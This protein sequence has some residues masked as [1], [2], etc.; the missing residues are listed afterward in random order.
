MRKKVSILVVLAFVSTL[1]LSGFS[2][3]AAEEESNYQYS[4]QDG[5]ATI[6]KYIGTEAVITVPQTLDGYSVI[7]IGDRAF[8]SCT[9]LTD[10]T[11]LSGVST[12]ERYAFVACSHLLNIT[13]P[14]TITNIGDLAFSGT[15][16]NKA[17]IIN[18]GTTLCYVPKTLRSYYIPD[19]VTTIN[20]RVFFGGNFYDIV[21]PDSVKTIG[22]YSFGYCDN[23]TDITMPASVESIAPFA[24]SGSPIESPIYSNYGKVLCHI[25]ETLGLFTIPSTVEEIGPTAFA[26]CYRLM[27]ITI[28][29]KVSKIGDFAFSECWKLHSVSMSDNVVSIGNYAFSGCEVLENFSMSN[30]LTSIGAYAFKDCP[31]KSFIIPE[32]LET[33]GEGAFYG[34]HEFDSISLPDSITSLSDFVFMNCSKMY[35]IN[36][37]INLDSIGTGAFLSCK[38]LN[39]IV[40][41]D[42]INTIE[43]NAFKFDTGLS[44]ITFPDSL[45]TIGNSVFEGCT[46]L[47]I[48]EATENSMA[49]YYAIANNITYTENK[50][51]DSPEFTEITPSFARAT[52]QWNSV[53]GATGY[54]LY[55]I[56]T[57][58]PTEII[59]KNTAGPLTETTYNLTGLVQNN[60]YIIYVKAVNGDGESMTSEHKIFRTLLSGFVV[61]GDV[62]MGYT[63]TEKI[64]NIP[65]EFNIKRINIDAFKNNENITSVIVPEGVESVEHPFT[66]CSNLSSVSLPNSVTY[67]GPGTFDYT[68]VKSPV[69]S[70]DNTK[71]FYVPRTFTN[72]IVPDT[73]TTINFN[74]FGHNSN[75][76]SVSLPTGLVN[77]DDEAFAECTALNSINIPSTVQSIGYRAFYKCSSITDIEIPSRAT[78]LEDEIFSECY[79]L[80]NATINEGITIIPRRTFYGCMSIENVS[81]PESLIKI[82]NSAFY[83]CTKL[84]SI[85]LPINLETVETSAF[86]LCTVLDNVIIPTNTKT[87]N[88]YAF[89]DCY[90]LHSILIPSTITHL[91]RTTI[92]ISVALTIYGDVGSYAQS[93]ATSNNIKFRTVAEFG[94]IPS[95]TPTLTPTATPTP[96]PTATPTPVAVTGIKLNKTAASLKVNQM[97]QLTATISPINATN[98]SCT[99]K[100]SNTKIA[101]VSSTGKI[102]ANAPGTAIITVTTVSGGKIATCKITVV[103]PV[104]SVK[105]NKTVLTLDKGKTY[106]LIATINPSNATNK[107]VT[108]KSGNSSIATVSSTGIVKGIKKGTTYV[109]VYTVDGKKTAK[110]KVVIK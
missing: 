74:T 34:C 24:F 52:I 28:P 5:K 98:N 21:I 47:K 107:K 110:C 103:Q 16:I 9:S 32:T 4:I 92:E 2:P 36:L 23:L 38:R 55:L 45:V 101:T 39:K 37:P 108:W 81:L 90:S 82:G 44:V 10:V 62:L 33:L 59:K 57:N 72:Y 79:K 64:V 12:I 18:S 96:T 35:S 56:N 84:K 3:V 61:E 88:N 86:Q 40:L 65:E 71:L 87:I 51:L 109:Y 66:G 89:D 41:P 93:F 60:D 100:S 75:L 83:E 63:G 26:N 43:D 58:H 76:L 106:K 69:L 77:I 11:I 7:T 6:T 104:I 95:P 15:I 25:K 80:K 1:Y 20:N 85:D 68:N 29:E 105:L 22:E 50:A 46:G 17:I 99:W 94:T 91:E 30:S 97:M 8:S 54:N 19:G 102:T 73:V 31:I 13:L 67:L 48:F 14:D 70:R 78:S 49:R 42:T 27:S 53:E